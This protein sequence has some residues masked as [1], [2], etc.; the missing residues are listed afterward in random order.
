MA[1][2][3]RKEQ[4][5]CLLQSRQNEP[6]FLGS[7]KNSQLRISQIIKIPEEGKQPETS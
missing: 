3:K 6:T 5:Q 7:K 2:L 4:E 1:G